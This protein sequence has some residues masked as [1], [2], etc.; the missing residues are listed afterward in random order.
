[1]SLT[2]ILTPEN[3]IPLFT[4]HPEMVKA[5]FPHLPPDLPVPPSEDALRRIIQQ[6]KYVMYSLVTN[7]AT[8]HHSFVLL[9][10]TLIRLCAQVYS[11]TWL[12]V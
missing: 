6:V 8:A 3:L 7:C 9:C 5:L 11:G 1:M 4:S 10:P 2:D 12:E